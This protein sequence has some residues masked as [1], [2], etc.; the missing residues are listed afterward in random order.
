MIIGYALKVWLQTLLALILLAWAGGCVLSPWGDARR[1]YLWLAAPLAGVLALGGACIL[2][3]YGLR[4]PL[5]LAALTGLLVLGGVTLFLLFRGRMPFPGPGCRL[6]VFAAL[7]VSSAYGTYVCNWSALSAGTPTVA[8]MDGSDQFAYSMCADWLKGHTAATPP[9]P[10]VPLECLNYL[11]LFV[12]GS[13]PAAFLLAG[14]ASLF[15]G[16]TAIFSYDWANGVLLAGAVAG[17][18]GLFSARRRTLVILLAAG[19]TSAWLN[20]ARTG[21]LGK[22]LAYPGCLLLGLLFLETVARPSRTRV[23]AACL[24]SAATAFCHNPVVPVLVLGLVLGGYLAG[25]LL[26]RIIGVRSLENSDGTAISSRLSLRAIGLYLAMVG[27]AYIFHRVMFGGLVPPYDLEWTL[28]VPVALDLEATALA[29][30]GPWLSMSLTAIYLV[31]AVWLMVIAFRR[32]DLAALALL[33]T[34]LLVPLA[35][36]IGQ[37]RIYGFY[38]LLY[39]LTMAGAALLIAGPRDK[40]PGRSLKAPAWI[41][42]AVLVCLHLPQITCSARRYLKQN[43]IY[44]SVWPVVHTQRDMDAIRKRVGKETVDL[45]FVP[46]YANTY[47][48][49]LELACQ[50]S[51]VLMRSPAWDRCLGPPARRL[52]CA[53][54]SGLPPKGRFSIVE[55]NG[56]APAGTMRIRSDNVKLCEDQSAVS[57]LAVHVAPVMFAWDESGRPGFWLGENGVTLDIYNGTGAARTVRFLGRAQTFTPWDSQHPRLLHHSFAGRT[58]TIEVAARGDL[59]TLDLNLVEGLNKLTLWVGE[60][61]Q[62]AENRNPDPQSLRL[63][64]LR[65]ETGSGR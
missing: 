59:I 30:V 45:G 8:I 41:L 21:Y 58:E 10:D 3:Y 48:M 7:L 29:M 51:N 16:T 61:S 19:M 26:L 18:A 25:M 2:F 65:L 36:L 54:P 38:G 12:D 40:V 46:N 50:G 43:L 39:P 63:C 57:L 11:N 1:P 27:P 5:W 60:S 32:R 52:G 4:L 9:R 14:A 64:N 42:A 17:L 55:R 20:S 35:W 28:V 37:R 34:C 31:L 47:M 53:P 33:T 13:R 15:R 44:G 56:F 62:P 6:P 49:I 24:I 23:I 22:S